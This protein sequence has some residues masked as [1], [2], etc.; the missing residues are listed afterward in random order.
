MHRGIPQLLPGKKSM[1]SCHTASETVCFPQ[2]EIDIQKP[3]VS[4][5]RQLRSGIPEESFSFLQ[6]PD[7]LI[8]MPPEVPRHSGSDSAGQS[9]YIFLSPIL[10]PKAM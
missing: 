4:L 10:E 9:I 3:P 5:S 1:E 2:S 8:L 6:H 7:F